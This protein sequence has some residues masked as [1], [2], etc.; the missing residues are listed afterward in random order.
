MKEEYRN[1]FLRVRLT[2]NEKKIISEKAKEEGYP[3]ISTYVRNIVLKRIFSSSDDNNGR[4]NLIDRNTI[5]A[6]IT[7]LNR[8]GVN[9]NQITKAVNSFKEPGHRL[10]TE[11]V[12]IKYLQ[13][14]ANNI[15]K[16]IQKI[17]QEK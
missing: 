5:T 3:T 6:A 13:E 9:I 10:E 16:L 15:L 17:L 14:E 11:V 2:P 4:L 7:E 12:K 8:I 1:Y